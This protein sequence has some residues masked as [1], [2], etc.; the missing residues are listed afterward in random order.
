VLFLEIEKEQ[1]TSHRQEF[2]VLLKLKFTFFRKKSPLTTILTVTSS[3]LRLIVLK[4]DKSYVFI[5]LANSRIL[6]II[7]LYI[8]SLQLNHLQK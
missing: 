8:N 1:Y 3:S 4:T 5:L 7:Q 6:K 2:D